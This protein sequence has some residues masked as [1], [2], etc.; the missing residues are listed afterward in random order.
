MGGDGI[1]IS[2]SLNQNIY[3]NIGK[4]PRGS[5]LVT[6]GIMYIHTANNVNIKHS[7]G[8]VN[9]LL[10]MPHQSTGSVHGRILCVS[11]G[12]CRVLTDI[13]QGRGV[14]LV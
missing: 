14:V 9:G 1:K 11:V 13:T 5:P 10:L 8:V 4:P 12:R 6:L 2:G 3:C 7:L